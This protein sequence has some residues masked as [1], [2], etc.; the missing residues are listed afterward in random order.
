MTSGGAAARIRS[1][2]FGCRAK[3][4]FLAS[5]SSSTS[6][7]CWRTSNSISASSVYRASAEISAPS[8]SAL[9][10]IGA[11]IAGLVRPQRPRRWTDAAESDLGVAIIELL[12]DVG[13]AL[14]DYQ[15]QIAAEARLRTLRRSVLVFGALVI[16]VFWRCRSG[17]DTADG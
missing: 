6:S 8:G 1:S 17:D 7:M 4:S 10:A 13:D 14:A 3:A 11:I 15:E 5:I 9:H 16:L 12:A 2:S